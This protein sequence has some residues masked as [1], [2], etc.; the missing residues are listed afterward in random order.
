MLNMIRADFYRLFRIKMAYI[1]VASLLLLSALAIW[2]KTPG[3]SL[4]SAGS[5]VQVEEVSTDNN[6]QNLSDS[7]DAIQNPTETT[8]QAIKLD[9]KILEKNINLYYIFIFLVGVIVVQDFSFNSIKNSLTSAI[10]RKTYFISK[11]ATS[12]I[13]CLTVAF[14]HTLF[15]YLLNGFLNG[16]SESSS[17]VELLRIT[18][19]QTPY[20]IGLV[21]LLM[22][23]IFTFQKAASFYGFSIS[24]LMVII[25]SLLFIQLSGLANVV[26]LLSLEPQTA[27]GIVAGNPDWNYLSKYVLVGFGSF[28]LFTSIGYI[29]FNRT[30]IH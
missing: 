5:E 27:L 18:L 4:F 6:T 29:R 7:L 9:K 26:T 21:G 8:S 11:V 13:V 12:L 22:A 14:G 1:A 24:V 19:Y 2:Q 10:S 28:A 16:F 15:V 30:E 3:A 25:V 17:L 20:F 23:A